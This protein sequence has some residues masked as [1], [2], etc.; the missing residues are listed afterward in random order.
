MAEGTS[1]TTID[2]I[3]EFLLGGADVGQECDGIE[4]AILIAQSLLHG[5]R[6]LW[7]SQR[8]FIGRRRSMIALDHSRPFATL[9]LQ[10]EGR[11]EEVDVEPCR[12]IKAAHHARRFDGA[13]IC[14]E[15]CEGRGGR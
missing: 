1:G 5:C 11:L 13:M 3:A 4:R 2:A 10:L 14:S 9:L 15:P 8:P 12:R 6:P 7:M